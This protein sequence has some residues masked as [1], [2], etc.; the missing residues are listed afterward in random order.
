MPGVPFTSATATAASAVAVALRR[1]RKASNVTPEFAL[2]E[3]LR[4]LYEATQGS[5]RSPYQIQAARA[6]LSTLHDIGVRP[7]QRDLAI[8]FRGA[9]RDVASEPSTPPASEEKSK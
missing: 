5:I 2:T 7:S 3:A 8:V 9:K 4:V 6:I 1:K